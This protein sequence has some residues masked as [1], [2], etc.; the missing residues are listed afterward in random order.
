MTIT[1][2]LHQLKTIQNQQIIAPFLLKCAIQS[3]AAFELRMVH[4]DDSSAITNCAIV[5]RGS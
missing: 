2:V 3:Q 1:N 5:Q 4:N